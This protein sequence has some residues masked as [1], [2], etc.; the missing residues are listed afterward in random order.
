VEPQVK[1]VTPAKAKESD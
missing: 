1:A